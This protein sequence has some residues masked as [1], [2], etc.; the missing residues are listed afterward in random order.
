MIANSK[1]LQELLS[2]LSGLVEAIE[3]V[4]GSTANAFTKEAGLL[5]VVSALRND[6]MDLSSAVERGVVE[7]APQDKR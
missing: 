5:G 2:R 6:I 7:S 1:D 3:A 4:E